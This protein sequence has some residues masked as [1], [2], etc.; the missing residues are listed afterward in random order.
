M[1]LEQ[2]HWEVSIGGDRMMLRAFAA[3]SWDGQVYRRVATYWH[4]LLGKYG[5]ALPEDEL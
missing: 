5:P 4:Y 1:K 3:V 2:H